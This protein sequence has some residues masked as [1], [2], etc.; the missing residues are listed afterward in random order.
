MKGATILLF[1]W[2][3]FAF[4]CEKIIEIDINQANP[5]ITIQSEFNPD[6]LITVNLYESISVLSKESFPVISDASV[7]IHQN[8][9]DENSYSL[10]PLGNGVYQTNVYPKEGVSYSIEVQKRGFPSAFASDLIPEDTAEVNNIELRFLQ[11]GNAEI[12]FIL[13]DEIGNHYYEFYIETSYRFENSSETETSIDF[14][15]SDDLVFDHFD[16]A[17][18]FMFTDDVVFDGVKKPLTLKTFFSFP[19][20]RD[21][22]VI[23]P[24]GIEV[25]STLYVRTLSEKLFR[26]KETVKLQRDL[27]DDPFSEPVPINSNIEGGLGIFGGFNTAKYVIFDSSE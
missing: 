26:F 4:N 12:D 15:T 27:E 10:T 6:S 24:P 3:L 11:N 18:Q 9:L 16:E 2:C 14:L 13:Q 1:A 5:K 7:V 23:V 17:E 20:S 19:R 25:K 22:N 8:S 21:S